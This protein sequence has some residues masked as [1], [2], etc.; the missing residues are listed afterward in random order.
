M[1]KVVNVASTLYGVHACTGVGR[2]SHK[3]ANPMAVLVTHCIK[4]HSDDLPHSAPLQ[5][6]T[7]H[8]V[9]GDLYNLLEAE[10]ARVSGT[11]QLLVRYGTQSFHKV[12]YKQ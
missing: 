9:V 4:V 8:V 1:V 7:V 10:H 12:N 11:G 5:P 2:M 6:H 3:E